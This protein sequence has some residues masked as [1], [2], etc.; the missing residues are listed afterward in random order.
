VRPISKPSERTQRTTIPFFKKKDGL[1]QQR[2]A[3][4]EGCQS[5]ITQTQMNGDYLRSLS[6]SMAREFVRGCCEA[7]RALENE[8]EVKQC[9]YPRACKD[10]D[11]R[12]M[13]PQRYRSIP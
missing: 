2:E 13:M 1:L 4:C 10:C 6:P 5:V 12:N 3:K 9:W 7:I 11:R 8:V